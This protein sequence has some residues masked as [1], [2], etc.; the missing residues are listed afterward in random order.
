MRRRGLGLIAFQRGLGE[1][2]QALFELFD[3]LFQLVD[4]TPLIG[5]R[6]VEVV[7]GILLESQPGL[8]LYE[9]LL[10]GIQEPGG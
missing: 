3:P 9:S 6:L 10:H 7:N 4:L 5:H 2:L 1:T 8:Q